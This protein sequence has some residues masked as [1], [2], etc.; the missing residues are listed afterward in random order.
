MA[1]RL[2]N[3]SK[4]TPRVYVLEE[5]ELVMCINDVTLTPGSSPYGQGRKCRR[6]TELGT[7]YLGGGGEDI[8]RLSC[9]TVFALLPRRKASC[10]NCT[11]VLRPSGPGVGGSPAVKPTR[12]PTLFCAAAVGAVGWSLAP[13]K[14]EALSRNL[15][16]AERGDVGKGEE[17]IGN[18][19][20][21]SKSE[22]EVLFF[23]AQWSSGTG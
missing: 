20:S 11:E 7:A 13:S 22:K 10:V 23:R 12:G 4:D 15:I 17:G 3:V 19:G 8:L 16:G 18:S 21:D 2:S 6:T 9:G 14:Y 5:L 1:S